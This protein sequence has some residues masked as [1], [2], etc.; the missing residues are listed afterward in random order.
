VNARLFL[1]LPALTLAAGC[2]PT[3]PAPGASTETSAA[4]SGSTAAGASSSTAAG[5]STAA[6]AAAPTVAPVTV[7]LDGEEVGSTKDRDLSAKLTLTA[8]L[9]EAARDAKGWRAIEAQSADGVRTLMLHEYAKQYGEYEP[10][11]YLEEPY[12][13]SLG[14]FRRLEGQEVP[15]HARAELEKPHLKLVGVTRVD[16]FT[17]AAKPEAPVE[18]ATVTVVWKG[19]ERSLGAELDTLE[20]V[21]QPRKVDGPNAKPRD[22]PRDARVGVR[23][24][25]VIGLVASK[26]DVGSVTASGDGKTLRV[27]GPWGPKGTL[28]ILRRTK[29]GRLELTVWPPGATEPSGRLRDVQ[30]LELSGAT[31]PGSR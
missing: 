9:P 26:T 15:A 29:R 4:P 7:F 16:V 2:E 12:G 23:L 19:K 10:R 14:L 28:A 21:S 1:V 27:D 13:P 25:D 3:P 5:T 22:K 20:V 24:D 17:K 8:L 11:L 18:P 6:S 30:R 31:T